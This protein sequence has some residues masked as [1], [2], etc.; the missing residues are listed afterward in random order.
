MKAWMKITLAALIVLLVAAQIWYSSRPKGRATESAGPQAAAAPA[1][2]QPVEPMRRRALD[3][4]PSQVMALAVT[5]PDHALEFVRGTD[6]AWTAQG[7][8]APAGTLNTVALEQWLADLAAVSLDGTGVADEQMGAPTHSVVITLADGTVKTLTARPD[9]ADADMLVHSSDM[10]G[11]IFSLPFWRFEALLAR[12]EKLFGPLAPVF[13]ADD[14]RT[15]DIRTDG[16]SVKLVLRDRNW[17]AAA[18]PF[19]VRQTRVARIARCLAD[20]HSA[21]YSSARAGRPVFGSPQL[22]VTLADGTVHQYRLGGRH[23]IFAWRY[24]LVDGERILAVENADAATLFPRL[25]EILDLGP[26]FDAAPE[27]VTAIRAE[28]RMGVV[29]AAERD[30]D[31][32]WRCTA[33]D[34]AGA[35]LTRTETEQ[36]VLALLDWQ[37]TDFLEDS[38]AA[39]EDP[40]L[41]LRLWCGEQER[42]ISLYSPRRRVLPYLGDDGSGFVMDRSAFFAWL[43]AVRALAHRVKQEQAT[44][45]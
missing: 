35:E 7:I 34:A 40:M 43:G 28:G 9:T 31:G 14:I 22:E 6:G 26:V 25:N 36:L 24:V 29:L 38:V 45:E 12:H 4:V 32:T 2:Q 44:N 8:A 1:M 41:R 42:S 17:T 37:R 27:S 11:M 16:E 21:G 18:M 13:A 30:D 3:F 15:L 39:P 20:W 5:Y 10:P 33:G 19:A 23:P